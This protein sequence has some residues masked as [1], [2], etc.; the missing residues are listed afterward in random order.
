[1]AL[2]MAT[3]EDVRAFLERDWDAVAEEKA[4]FWSARKRELGAPAGLRISDE[5]R[6]QV[7]A[8]RSDWPTEEDRRADFEAHVLLSTMMKNVGSPRRR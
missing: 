6:R 5:L 3:I 1:M 8:T 2:P 4:R 7:M